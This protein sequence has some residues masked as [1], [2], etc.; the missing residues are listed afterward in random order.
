MSEI[1]LKAEVTKEL[2]F[3]DGFGVYS[4][5]PK[6]DH[7]VTVHK[8]YGTFVVSGNCPKLRER[9]IVNFT[10]EPTIS[11]KYGKGYGFVDF[12][13]PVLDTVEKQQT[14][15]KEVLATSYAE[16]LINTYPN[17][18]IL[19]LIINDEVDVSKLKGIGEA[20]LIKIT[21][22]VNE[23]YSL[24]SS[25]VEL[26]DLQVTKNQ[27]N[28]LVKFFGTQQA[29]ID[30][31][32]SN[33]YKL[34]DVKGFGFTRIDEY[35]MKRGD[36][37][38]SKSRIVA[39]ITYKL[40]EFSQQGDSYVH[41]DVMKDSIYELLNLEWN[42][43]NKVLLDIMNNAKSDIYIDNDI[44]AL[45]RIIN[46]EKSIRDNLFRLQDTYK[47][48]TEI[49]MENIEEKVG[50]TYTP[51]QREFILTTSNNGVVVL[52]GRAGTGKSAT[53]VGQTHTIP[54]VKD[55]ADTEIQDYIAC[56]LSGQA[57]KVLNARGMSARTIHSLILPYIQGDADFKLDFSVV[58]VDEMSMVDIFLFNNILNC[59][60]DGTQLI[61]VGDT[62]QL[63]AIG[64]GSPYIDT[65][66][67]EKFPHVDLK[68][69]HRQAQKSGILSYANKVYEGEQITN[70]TNA[71]TERLGELQDFTLMPMSN[72]D[73]ILPTI[74]KIVQAS[75]NK[76]GLE[77]VDRFIVLAANKSRGQLS[78]ANLNKELQSI[79][80]KKNMET[81]KPLSV[82]FLG[83]KVIHNGN[84]SDTSMYSNL[85]DY[86]KDKQLPPER[87]FNGSIGK[88]VKVDHV[89]HNLIIDFDDVEGLVAYHIDDFNYIS[90]AYAITIHRSQG[91]GI[92]NVLLTFDYGA[93]TLLSKQL[94]YTGMTRASKSLAM[95]VENSALHKAISTDLGSTRN[96]FLNELL[97][98]VNYLADI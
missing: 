14:Y 17:E 32:Q 27:L 79:F 29:L 10:I 18:K 31:V 44:I 43:I 53:V 68:T 96:T 19:D 88:I 81:T 74:R 80:N 54:Q 95:I 52:S 73:A 1:K 26:K 90:L 4:F 91:V 82:F 41:L 34:C 24:A 5:R 6:G 75:V 71:S 36:N 11:K 22:T 60:K 58:I 77:F 16:T 49:N 48:V 64:V 15:L 2:Y 33:I 67:S 89:N 38:E 72:K 23:F 83:D 61:L 93:Y 25:I 62:G 55:L 46:I 70:Y 76:H 66:Q 37:P 39:A 56:A 9:S 50:F 63:P 78:V 87:V 65:I 3:E 94:V 86:E 7:N 12:D 59:L 35:A 51:E 13:L 92:E 85:D 28:K 40:K 84:N 20:T 45:K 21:A 30:A 97:Q 47:K 8:E 98:N 69:V 57:V 42:V